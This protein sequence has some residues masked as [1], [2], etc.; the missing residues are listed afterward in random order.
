[1]RIGIT[2]VTEGKDK[3]L[4]YPLLFQSVDVVLMNKIGLPPYTNFDIERFDIL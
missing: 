4:K 3:P 2:S 1:M